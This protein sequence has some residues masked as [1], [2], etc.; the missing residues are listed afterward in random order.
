MKV[1]LTNED[2]LIEPETE[3]ETEYLSNFEVD[4][5]FHKTGQTLAHLLG[6]KIKRKKEKITES[7]A[8]KDLLELSKKILEDAEAERNNLDWPEMYDENCR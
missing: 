5:V 2:L 4:K 1:T 7:M 8:R 6:I 3:F